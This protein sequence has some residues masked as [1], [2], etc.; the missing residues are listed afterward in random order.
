MVDGIKR[1]ATLSLLIRC[2]LSLTMIRTVRSLASSVADVGQRT[3]LAVYAGHPT[4]YPEYQLALQAA[5][6]ESQLRVFLTDSQSAPESVE[7]IIYSPNGPI[8]DFSPF[9]NAKAVLCLWAGVEGVANNPT[10][11]RS[12]PLTRMVDPG[13]R[14]GMVEYVVGHVLRYHLLMDT[15]WKKKHQ[16]EWMQSDSGEYMLPLARQRTV[17]ILGLGELGGSCA[18]ALAKL[19]FKV[20]GWS[21][22][23]K[24]RNDGI[25]CV[26]GDSGLHLVLGQS[27][28]LV[29]LLP[30]TPETQDI[31][32]RES[33]ASCKPGIR[34]I[35]GGRGSAINEEDL[36]QAL[37]SGIVAGAT[38]DVFKTEPLPSNHGFWKHPNVLI[39]PHIAAK[40][41][42]DTASRVIA[43][44]IRR[45]EAGEPLLYVVDRDAGY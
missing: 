41:R 8:R 21:R 27:D 17:G 23:P 12:I 32:N 44:N 35:N 5:F 31:I 28:I 39:T 1:R 6:E 7:Y 2:L 33:L 9:A 36:L 4:R 29:L 30:N 37:D 25:Q 43:E 20:C 14:E 22:S 38:L 40:T 42:A 3:I 15:L 26:H 16:G 19:N 45:C 11:P 34:I 10:L 13:L 24:E 18:D